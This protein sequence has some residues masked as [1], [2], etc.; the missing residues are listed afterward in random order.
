MQSRTGAKVLGADP[1]FLLEAGAGRSSP[2]NGKSL[3]EKN[4]RSSMPVDKKVMQVTQCH[5]FLSGARMS[6]EVARRSESG[7]MQLQYIA[8]E[9]CQNTDQCDGEGTD[10]IEPEAKIQRGLK[11]L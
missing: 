1:P 4:E 6:P 9:V 8:L 7:S 3:S 2:R 5:C 10:V 11:V